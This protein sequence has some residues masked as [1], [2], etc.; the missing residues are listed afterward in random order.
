MRSDSAW[1]ALAEAMRAHFNNGSI[2]RL[3]KMSK[4]YI[5]IMPGANVTS[6]RWAWSAIRRQGGVGSPSHGFSCKKID[7]LS[8]QASFNR[9][10]S[11]NHYSQ[12]N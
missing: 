3:R 6:K 12:C 7:D 11:T 10:I 4:N 1:M 5:H 8:I 9:S 2:V